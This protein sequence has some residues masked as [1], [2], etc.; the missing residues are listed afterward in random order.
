LTCWLALFYGCLQLAAM[1]IAGCCMHFISSM[2]VLLTLAA[3]GA[4]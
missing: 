3:D 1:K 4:S 2:A